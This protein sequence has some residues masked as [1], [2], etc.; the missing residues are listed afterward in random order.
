MPLCSTCFA[1]LGGHTHHVLMCAWEP[2]GTQCW[3]QWM[4]WKQCLY[5]DLAALRPDCVFISSLETPPIPHVFQ[6]HPSSLVFSYR[7]PDLW[8]VTTL[9]PSNLPDI[10]GTFCQMRTAAFY[11]RATGHMLDN[12]GSLCLFVVVPFVVSASA[13]VSFWG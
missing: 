3:T 10:V 8:T 4:N 5:L 6:N 13:G 1:P 2:A 11:Y 9:R 12:S 7:H